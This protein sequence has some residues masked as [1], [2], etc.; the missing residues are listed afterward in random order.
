MS[1]TLWNTLKYVQN[2]SRIIIEFIKINDRLTFIFRN[3]TFWVIK[4]I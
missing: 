4:I 2:Y 1:R 3:I